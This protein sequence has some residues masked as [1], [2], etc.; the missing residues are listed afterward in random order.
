MGSKTRGEEL[1][2]LGHL[3]GQDS[4]PYESSSLNL[5]GNPDSPRGSPTAG[6]TSL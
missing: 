4:R 1:K 6:C 5:G 2:A 3:Q